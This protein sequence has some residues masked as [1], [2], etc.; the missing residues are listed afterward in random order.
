MEDG[1]NALEVMQND[2]DSVYF[3]DRK[4]RG[5]DGIINLL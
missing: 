3:L 1:S 4:E 5:I 2:T